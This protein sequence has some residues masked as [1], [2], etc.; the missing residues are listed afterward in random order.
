MKTEEEWKLMFQ[1]IA[2]QFKLYFDIDLDGIKLYQE[3]LR[4]EK[5]YRLKK[6]KPNRYIVHIANIYKQIHIINNILIREFEYK[7]YQ[8]VSNKCKKYYTLKVYMNNKLV[9]TIDLMFYCGGALD[10]ISM[11][12]NKRYIENIPHKLEV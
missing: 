3:N 6:K 11:W 12:E 4:M 7:L 1:K 10:L 2:N 8:E 5:E 9:S